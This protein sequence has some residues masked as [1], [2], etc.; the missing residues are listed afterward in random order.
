[1][2]VGN[3]LSSSHPAPTGVPQGACLSSLLYTI[4]VLD[5][6]SALPE[7]TRCLMFADDVF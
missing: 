6:S 5:L 7:G 3:T 4:F 2:K 1:M